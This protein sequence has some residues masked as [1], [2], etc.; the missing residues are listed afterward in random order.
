MK[1]TCRRCNKEQHI[2]NFHKIKAGD[3]RKNIC[4]T[5]ANQKSIDRYYANHEEMKQRAAEKRKRPDVKE[6]HRNY[7]LRKLFGITIEQYNVMGESQHWM[8]AICSAPQ[9]EN[10]HLHVDHSHNSGKVRGLLCRACNT[11]IGLMN[12]EPERLRKAISY[13]END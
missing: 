9:P 6:W 13:L 8:C 2:D 3:G 10:E 5:C 12:D 4:S 11:A 1:K 7:K